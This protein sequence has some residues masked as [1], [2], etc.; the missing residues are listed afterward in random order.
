[1]GLAGSGR[2]GALSGGAIVNFLGGTVDAT[3]LET[4]S[5]ATINIGGAATLTGATIL[6]N[7]GLIDIATDWTGSLTIAG[8]NW[9]TA[10]VGDANWAYNGSAIDATV[11]ANNFVVTGSTLSA[12]PEPGSLAL[13]GLGGLLIARRRRG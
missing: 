3:E 5:G 7:L 1:M 9:E 11:F 6:D 10:M 4:F 2:F 8:L 12:V 13:L